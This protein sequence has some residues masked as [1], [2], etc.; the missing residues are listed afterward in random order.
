MHGLPFAADDA[1]GFKTLVDPMRAEAAFF[2]PLLIRIEM[3][4]IIGADIHAG[5]TPVAARLV[6]Y[7]RAV[8]PFDKRFGRA[9]V[10]AGRGIAVIAEPGQKGH[11]QIRE[12]SL[13]RS[14]LDSI[15]GY[16]ANR[17]SRELIFRF[18]G[19]CAGLASDAPLLVDDHAESL[20]HFSTPLAFSTSTATS[21]ICILGS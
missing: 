13:G 5:L 19:H 2:H 9:Y 4:G 14:L 18:A 3:K 8:F 15:F 10:H 7:H 12:A 17:V 11:L 6:E 20:C 21:F 16:D 1:E